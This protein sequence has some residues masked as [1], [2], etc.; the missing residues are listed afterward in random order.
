MTPRQGCGLLC[1]LIAFRSLLW[2]HDI[3]T[4]FQETQSPL[5]AARSSSPAYPETSIPNIPMPMLVGGENDVRALPAVPDIP[6]MRSIS[7]TVPK[8]P[9]AWQEEFSAANHP[10]Q[11]IQ[12]TIKVQ[13]K[14][15]AATELKTGI[16][17]TG[18]GIGANDQSLDNFSVCNSLK[19]R[20][21]VS[22]GSSWGSMSKAQQNTWLANKCD[23]HF[24][25]PDKRIGRGVYK[26]KP[27]H[28][29][30]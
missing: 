12:P 16:N 2:I 22:P 13:R 27:L 30:R 6:P 24:C 10:N 9:A 4:N 21:G 18:V 29:Y 3:K 26:C 25:Q 7:S 15:P 5:V 1:V 14:W 19:D 17:S 20:H 28:A 8:F 11:I 23:L